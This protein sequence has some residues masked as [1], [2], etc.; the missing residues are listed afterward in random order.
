MGFNETL[1]EDTVTKFE[2][3]RYVRKNCKEIS[4]KNSTKLMHVR[5]VRPTMS[6]HN[7]KPVGHLHCPGA[8]I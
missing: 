4:W 2:E 3:S 1:D 7:N 6:N 8:L 5:K